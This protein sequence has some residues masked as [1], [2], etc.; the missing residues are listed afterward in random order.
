MQIGAKS[1]QYLVFFSVLLAGC[2]S[3]C[4]SQGKS[5][6]VIDKLSKN[7]KL[8]PPED[9]LRDFREGKA[10]TR[11][12]VNLRDPAGSD[13]RRDFKDMAA[14]RQLQ[15]DVKALQDRVINSLDQGDVRIT[16]R[17][18]YIFGFSAE[19]TLSGLQALV[20]NPHVLS[21]QADSVVQ[22]H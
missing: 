14:R 11:V 16:N 2:A 20:D 21:I 3:L 8:S 19:V 5:S 10:A 1:T 18:T 9:V 12:I 17:F 6:L 13:R 22:A 4:C 15:Q 7:P